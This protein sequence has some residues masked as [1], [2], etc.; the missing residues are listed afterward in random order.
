MAKWRVY[1]TRFSVAR[2]GCLDPDGCEAV[3]ILIE[4]D[5]SLQAANKAQ[6]L[7]ENN[8]DGSG[9]SYEDELV[10]TAVLDFPHRNYLEST[11]YLKDEG[12]T[13]IAE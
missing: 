7:V 6:T 11:L 3:G 2:T 4:A 5:T 8:G 10:V 1:G 13:L 9:A 12:G